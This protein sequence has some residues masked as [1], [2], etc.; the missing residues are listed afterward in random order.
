M[1]ADY[2]FY[3]GEVI[4][5][6][7]NNSI[8]DSVAIKENRILAV[9]E[10]E[11]LQQFIGEETKQI[12]LD[13]RSLLPGFNDAHLHLVYYGVNQLAIS[14]KSP[15][16]TSVETL[17]NA[18]K[19]KAKV[20]PP[21]RWIRAWGFNENTV[22]EQRYPTLEEL[23]AVSIEH[24][25]LISRTC[26][27]ISIL[28]QTA[29]NLANI[30]EHTPDPQGGVIEKDSNGKLTGRLIE[31][32]SMQIAEIATYSED[33]LKEGIKIANEHFL[34]TGITSVGEAGT[35]GSESFRTLQLAIQQGLLQIRVYALLG[36]LTD[37]KDFSE[38]IIASGVVTGTGNE[39]FRLGPVKLFTDGSS[40]GPTIATR[41]GYTSDPENHG[42]LYYSE[43][44]I[45]NVLGVAHKLGYQITVHAQGDKAIEMYLNVVERALKE[46]PRDNHRH[47]IEHAGI[48]TPDIQDRIKELGMVPI[49]N[50]PFHYEFGESYIR[51]YGERVNY[52]YPARDFIDKG[53]IAAAGSDSP[54][55][56][57]PPLLGIHTAV[58][59]KSK[60]GVD[61]GAEQAVE[62][63]EAI[64]MYTWNGAYASFE[65]EIKG[66]IEPG[67]LADII[68]LNGSILK[69]DKTRIK[70]LQIDATI[71][72][73]KI[74][75]ERNTNTIG[76][77][78]HE[79]H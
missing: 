51:N 23:N 41:E 48:S 76:G 13:G 31:A 44:E 27:H 8:V 24:P 4:T 5:V 38:K 20:T 26:G 19:E 11:S 46:H 75:F 55:T 53:I 7:A 43:E 60:N 33:E 74:A 16:Q 9:G 25:I 64:K 37:S 39:W 18:L 70:D 72:D 40:T 28:N 50:P 66:S 49:P 2:V 6:D 67:K 58:N 54:V 68:I 78:V 29:L 12:D 57:Y 77:V 22:T 1:V 14:C 36:S 3:N 62:V 30:D 45:Y 42:I 15:E 32:A 10:F 71:V 61:I 65:E 73:G 52:M 47:R 34:K 21:G 56:D 35:F 79:V 69:E 63:L 59:R 17:L